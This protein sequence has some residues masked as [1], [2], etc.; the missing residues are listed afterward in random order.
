M[1]CFLL[2]SLW[3][4]FLIPDPW[5]ILMLVIS[6]ALGLGLGDWLL[7]NAFR[8][9]G[10]GRTMML[11][12]FQPLI[13]GFFGF[14]FFDQ[15]VN[16]QKFWA[17]FFFICCLITISRE[18][19]RKDR[20][21]QLKGSSFALGGMILDG[22]GA[23]LTRSVFDQ[24]PELLVFEANYYRC[25]G[26]LFFFMIFARF[27]PIDLVKVWQAQSIK[28]QIILVIGSL[29][30]TFIS[31][32]LYVKALQTAHLASLSGVAIT[33]TLFSSVL[34]CLIKREWPSFSLLVAFMFFLGGM[35]FL[36]NY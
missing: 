34:E 3:L 9:I 2:T 19:F 31:L 18:S 15:V 26:A 10:P 6:G 12:G 4:G 8:D 7:L 29:L 28:G 24:Q 35:F 36:L 25:L 16:A 32:S 5:Q 1:L 23:V 11:F 14:V 21:Y 22:I 30:G 33:G 17:I 27:R 20:S 13:M